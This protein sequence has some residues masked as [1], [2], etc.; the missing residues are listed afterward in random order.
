MS[1]DTS[2]KNVKYRA[3]VWDDLQHTQRR[4]RLFGVI[5]FVSFLTKDRSRRRG[6]GN[7][8]ARRRQH[9]A[10]LDMPP[11]R[12]FLTSISQAAGDGLWG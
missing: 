7:V 10:P 1:S 11:C 4:G 9:A 5:L 6:W 3:R 12:P 2:H 8:D